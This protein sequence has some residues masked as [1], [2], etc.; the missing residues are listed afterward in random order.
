M[1]VL[2]AAPGDPEVGAEVGGD[3]QRVA[4]SLAGA[5]GCGHPAAV[6]AAALC[7]QRSHGMQGLRPQ[8]I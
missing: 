1:V 3:R 8:T 6:D 5:V 7:S 4:E 2:P